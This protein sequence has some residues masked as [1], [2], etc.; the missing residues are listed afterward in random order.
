[1]ATS[2]R[3]NRLHG[4]RSTNVCSAAG[5]TL[6]EMGTSH[7][8]IF[9]TRDTAYLNSHL[10]FLLQVQISIQAEIPQPK[11]ELNNSIAD[12]DI[13]AALT[14]LQVTLEGTNI[15]NGCNDITQ[16]PKLYDYLRFLKLV[17]KF[18]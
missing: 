5:G 6:D 16:V 4:G 3:R 13:D 9:L 8:S 11:I 7:F 14:D 2:K 12:D 18:I 10:V 15:S 17:R 1:M